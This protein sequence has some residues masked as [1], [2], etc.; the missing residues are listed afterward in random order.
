MTV[1]ANLALV[2]VVLVALYLL[3]LGAASLAAPTQAVRFLLGFAG[4]PT[5]HFAELSLRLVAGAALVLHAPNM[6]LTFAFELLG[7]MLVITTAA[8]LLLPWHWH[9]R[10]AERAVP[11]ATRHIALVGWASLSFGGLLL[12]ALSR[13]NAP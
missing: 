9:R 3:A 7:W 8:L 4:S 10:F 2:V 5:V 12:Y 11:R 6:R 13:G 1:I